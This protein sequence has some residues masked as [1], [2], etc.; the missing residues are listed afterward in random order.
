MDNDN[1]YKQ[2]VILDP[3]QKKKTD[4]YIIVGVE[5]LDSYDNM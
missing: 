3:E 1:D 5:D 4:N 2:Y